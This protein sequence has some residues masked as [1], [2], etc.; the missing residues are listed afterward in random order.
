M[1]THGK[2]RALLHQERPLNTADV[3]EAAD[4]GWEGKEDTKKNSLPPPG[5]NERLPHSTIYNMFHLSMLGH[6][7]FRLTSS[8]L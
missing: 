1:S 2:Y 3:D 7:G 4:V 6:R 5:M 8:P